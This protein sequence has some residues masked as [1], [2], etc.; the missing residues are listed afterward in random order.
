MKTDSHNGI[1]DHRWNVG[2]QRE[3]IH[4]FTEKDL[5]MFADLT[6]DRN[7]IHMDAGFASTS[8]VG[9]QV[10][11]GMLA[12]SF[13]STLIGMEIPGPGSL[14]NTFQVNWREVIRLGDTIR[15]TASITAI[16]SVLNMIVLKIVGCD[17][18]D[19]DRVF[20]DGVA[21][22]MLTSGKAK[23]GVSAIEIDGRDEVLTKS[24]TGKPAKCA[25]GPDRED[26]DNG[27]LA[28]KTVVV[29]GATGLL[30]GAICKRLIRD[31]ARI[32]L[33]GRDEDKLHAMK[34]TM[35]GAVA[36]VV[37]CDLSDITTVTRSAEILSQGH[38][39][40]GI[41]HAAAA[42]MGNLNVT[43][44]RSVEELHTHLFV[45]TL[46]LQA[47]VA[48]FMGS[49]ERIPGR[50]II[51]VLTQALFDAPP[52]KM[53]AYVSAKM[54]CWSLI[55]SLALELGPRG[56][57]SNAVSPGLM[58]TP[59]SRNI[60]VVAKKIEEASNPMRRLCQPQ[61]VA[62]AI[63]FLYSPLSGFI[64]GVNLPVTGG[65]RMP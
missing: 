12:A 56:V 25:A 29:T 27:I 30:G 51:A 20:L 4:R 36:D 32:I 37:H 1:V 65:L 24:E 40:F 13:I 21:K 54:A 19:S 5:Q 11:H 59:Y 60:S 34:E 6:G 18:K 8:A 48:A 62:E 50:F 38:E 55:R 53:S 3:I 64:N 45:E 39:V 26:G 35:G 33:W 42:R 7:P 2:D 16:N 28:K 43:D 44:S 23:E 15:F 9:G 61:D 49:N 10:V 22:V 41:V 52:A 57:R 46:S 58:E 47:L 17:I 31:G 14:W 63:A